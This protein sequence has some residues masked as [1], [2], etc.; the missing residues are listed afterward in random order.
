MVA[1]GPLDIAEIGSTPNLSARILAGEVVVVR[2]GLQQAGLFGDMVAASLEGVRAAAGPDVA[3]EVARSGFDRIHELV[4]P[5]DLP[6]V[7]DAVY[8]VMTREASPFLDRLVPRLFPEGRHLYFESTPNVRFHIPFS[9]AAPHRRQFDDFAKKHGQGKIT[10]HAPHRDAWLDCPDNTINVWIAVGPVRRGNGLTVF[11]ESYRT[12]MPFSPHGEVTHGVRLDKPMTFDL[13]AGDMV[14]FHSHH[15]HGSE[16]N[17]TDATRYVVSYRIA[18]GRPHFPRGH[19]HAYRHAGL[20]RG[21]LRAIAAWPAMMQL[22]YARSLARRAARRLWSAPARPAARPAP[23]GGPN[24]PIALADLP[25]G[26]IRAA[27][28]TVCVARLDDRH[29]AAVSRFCP[30]AGADLADG[31]IDGG[32]IV[33]PWHNVS[34]DPDSGASSCAALQP[35]RRFAAEAYVA[36]DQPLAR[37]PQ[38]ELFPSEAATTPGDRVQP[39]PAAGG[40]ARPPG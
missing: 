24:G 39:A 19:Y 32:R 23:R 6:A 4:A 9:A 25:V 40:R 27:S 12:V 11:A 34:F 16:L 15:L 17:R 13:Q 18:F 3:G 30:H 1:P 7:T 14:L 36:L 20:A 33:C 26:A 37:D 35:L 10:P 28:P 21:R 29:L 22:S 38:P 31:F 8:A 5:G 2:R